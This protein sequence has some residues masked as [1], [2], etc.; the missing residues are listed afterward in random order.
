[1]QG[2]ER[3]W[4]GFGDLSAFFCGPSVVATC[5]Q[6]DVWTAANRVHPSAIQTV[7]RRAAQQAELRETLCDRA[8]VV[9]YAPPRRR[10]RGRSV[11]APF[12]RCRSCTGQLCCCRCQDGRRHMA[13]HLAA[14][15]GQTPAGLMRSQP[16]RSGDM[17]PSFERHCGTAA[18][19]RQAESDRLQNAATHAQ[20]HA[21]FIIAHLSCYRQPATKS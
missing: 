1:M 15:G 14:R 3:R 21:T 8:S 12:R 5:W 6:C 18:S 9:P 11:A 17:P 19:S 10:T 13:R 20:P 4:I 16:L 7:G 2:A